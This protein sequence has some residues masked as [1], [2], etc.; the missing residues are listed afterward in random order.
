MWKINHWI[1]YLGS[2]EKAPGFF[3]GF[4]VLFNLLFESYH[5]TWKS[6][7]LRAGAPWTVANWLPLPKPASAPLAL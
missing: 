1:E 3:W 2:M 4:L 6:L 5:W 7:V